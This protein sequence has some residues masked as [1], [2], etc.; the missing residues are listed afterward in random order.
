MNFGEY[1]FE[2]TM[3]R[4][5]SF[6]VKLPI[7]FPCLLIGIIL[8]QHPE[9]VHPKEAQNKK[10][11]PLTFDYRQFVRTHVPDIAVTNHQDQ[12]VVGNSS[13]LSKYTKKDVL[14][15]L[16]KVSKYLQ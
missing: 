6:V 4:V 11:V 3:K 1:V 16:M 12:Y 8:N 15:K 7:V 14:L 13:P 2:Q 9:V 5:N 10:A